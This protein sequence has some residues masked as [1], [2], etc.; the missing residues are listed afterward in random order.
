MYMYNLIIGD[1]IR[2]C[3]AQNFSTI[4]QD[5]DSHIN[6]DCTQAVAAGGTVTVMALSSMANTETTICTN[7][8]TGRRS[9]AII[10]RCRL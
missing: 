10:I 1:S 8:S 3:N 9:T 2:F 5:N 7:A 4:V 6:G